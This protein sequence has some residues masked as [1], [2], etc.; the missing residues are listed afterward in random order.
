MIR[1]TPG[2]ARDLHH[3]LVDWWGS[4]QAGWLIAAWA[5]LPA[6]QWNPAVQRAALLASDTYLVTDEM[7]A[8]CRQA[9]YAL[10][11]LRVTRAMLP[12][13]HGFVVFN[14]NAFDHETLPAVMATPP[15]GTYAWRTDVH[16][17]LPGV[18]VNSYV[19]LRDRMQFIRQYKPEEYAKLET[20]GWDPAQLLERA[21]SPYRAPLEPC[22]LVFVPF[23]EGIDW[24][25]PVHEHA[26]YTSMQILAAAWLLMD[27]P[28]TVT[29]QPPLQR[30]F[31]RR[32]ER[33]GLSTDITV[34]LL[35][36]PRSQSDGD[37]TS[38]RHYHSRWIVQGHW[39]RI[40]TPDQPHRITWV[41]GHVKGP[42][43]APLVVRDRVTVLSR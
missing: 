31:T 11:E 20:D 38:G 5:E 19:D 25:A 21:L 13:E 18:W 36:R 14:D 34:V 3:R 9:G 24:A 7:S 10:A 32:A 22:D 35:R 28:I 40:P 26:T 1:Y 12:S 33:A 16:A 30:A 2:T 23:D 41:H 15:A 27:Q 6:N 43:D 17:G 37:G 8:V 29:E 42:A 4:A 39:R